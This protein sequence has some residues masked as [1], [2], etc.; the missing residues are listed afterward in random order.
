[1]PSKRFFY[2]RKIDLIEHILILEKRYK[3]VPMIFCLNGHFF[4]WADIETLIRF[5]EDNATIEQIVLKTSGGE[6]EVSSL[7]DYKKI[8]DIDFQVLREFALRT[9][10]PEVEI[11]MGLNNISVSSI[12]AEDTKEQEARIARYLS[13]FLNKGRTYKGWFCLGDHFVLQ[14]PSNCPNIDKLF[15]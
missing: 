8:V 3:D 1:M 12:V 14:R 2:Q 9:R 10:N 4:Q 11:D 7:G 6:Y 5:M 13:M 15:E